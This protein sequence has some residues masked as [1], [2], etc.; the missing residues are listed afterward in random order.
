MD[1][2]PGIHYIL[3]ASARKDIAFSNRHPLTISV[4]QALN[5]EACDDE[6]LIVLVLEN[7]L[8]LWIVRTEHRLAVVRDKAGLSVV[9]SLGT[10]PLF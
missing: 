6:C 3:E 9:T 7:V 5:G 8:W 10:L 1:E 4:E 2:L